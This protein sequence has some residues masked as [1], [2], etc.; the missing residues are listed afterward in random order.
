MSS[1]IAR[2]LIACMT[3]AGIGFASD[4]VEI[5]SG[6]V[7][8]ALGEGSPEIVEVMKEVEILLRTDEGLKQRIE[9]ESSRYPTHDAVVWACARSVA[10]NQKEFLDKFPHIYQ[11]AH[12]LFAAPDLY[13]DHRVIYQFMG[14][15][16]TPDP[17][18]LFGAGDSPTVVSVE[19]VEKWN[20]SEQITDWFGRYYTLEKKDGSLYLLSTAIGR[21]TTGATFIR[22]ILGWVRIE[23]KKLVPER[24]EAFDVPLRQERKPEHLKVTALPATP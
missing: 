7:G 19:R 15:S 1:F 4:A 23:A 9:S 11:Y 13:Q 6:H 22:H 24:F 5:F 16:G 2:V 20:D 12:V 3:L 18:M 21:E 10:F 14:M 17:R 8:N